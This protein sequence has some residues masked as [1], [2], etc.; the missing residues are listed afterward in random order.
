[1]STSIREV[2]DESMKYEVAEVASWPLVTEVLESPYYINILMV[3]P[4]V[5]S[6]TGR[7]LCLA[8]ALT[9]RR[10]HTGP[11]FG[12]WHT[13]HFEARVDAARVRSSL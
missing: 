9:P 7:V 2:S 10:R 13:S 5:G 8:Q 12:S 3:Y 6:H 4:L 1:M 11:G